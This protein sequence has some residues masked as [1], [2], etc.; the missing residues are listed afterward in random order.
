MN[1]IIL[2]HN[3]ESS[4]RARFAR[5]SWN[6]GYGD[7]SPHPRFSQS[8]QNIL[9]YCRHINEARGRYVTYMIGRFIDLSASEASL[10]SNPIPKS[11]KC[12]LSFPLSD[13]LNYSPL[14]P[15]I[16]QL[17]RRP[18]KSKTPSLSELVNY[19]TIIAIN[20]KVSG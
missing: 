16:D 20:S 17:C 13:V 7:V 5:P 15:I 2:G 9:F 3:I 14:H 19:D 18:K 6:R 10:R 8:I 12:L 11:P 4:I 1:H